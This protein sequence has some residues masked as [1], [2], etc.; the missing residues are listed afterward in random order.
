MSTT[1]EKATTEPQVKTVWDATYTL[2]RKLGLTTIFGNP[3]S[4]EQPFLKNFPKDFQ[5]VLGLQEASVVAMADA[6]SQ[7]TKKP[8][9]VN[10]HSCAGTGNG[11]GN[12]MTAY[13]NKTPLIITAGQQTREMLLGDPYL[14][15]RDETLLPRPWVKWAYQ[16]VRAQD[17]PGAIM[18]AYAAALQPPA[19]PVYLSI[20]LDDWDKP[21]LGEATLR[22]V[23]SRYAPDPDRVAMFADRIH[24]SKNPVL[25]YGSEI[26]RADGW[27]AGI[28]FAE[29]LRAP[30]YLASLSDRASFP[31]THP[32]FRGMAQIAIGPLS[33][34]L[35]GHD[36]VIVIGAEVFRYYPYIPGDYLPEGTELLQVTSDPHDAASAIVGESLLSDAKLA[37]E[38]LREAIPAVTSRPAPA[39]ARNERNPPASPSTPLTAFEAFAALSELRPDDAILVNETA[40]NFA[41]LL[42]HWPIGKPDTYYTFA[43]GG[44]GWGSPAAVGVALAE[45][46][47]GTGRPVVAV[48]GDGAFQYSVQDMYTAV[49][50]QLKVIF[51]VP[52]NGEYAI[53]KEFA[54]LEKT[55][56]VPGL[57]LPGLDPVSAA[58][59]FGCAGVWAKTKKE[60]KQAFADA[61]KANGPTL[62]GIPIAVEDRPLVAPVAS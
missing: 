51:V 8:V 33:Q 11:M 40:S 37:L 28:K 54:L 4:T 10:L 20:P 14:T 48:I 39:P 58:K 5:Y 12:I 38:A 13:Q 41:D 29:H 21:A 52:C 6:F 60:I 25:I 49:Q 31:Q 1:S 34:Q 23:S 43:S 27:E 44:L 53:L 24:K 17:V 18:R 2:L 57:D 61:L 9:L 19:G 7:A 32:Q 3:G 15:N 30:V 22:T 50:N 35:R 62:I 59:G 36:L 42:H 46:K 47:Q 45:K 16:P 55:P 26:E 56:N